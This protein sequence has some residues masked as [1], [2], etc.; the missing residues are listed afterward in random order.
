MGNT[1]TTIDLVDEVKKHAGI[2]SDYAL[3][4][5]LDV[6]PQTISHYRH[7][8]TQMSDEIAVKLS[9]MIGRPPAPILATLAAE[10]SKVPEVARIWQDAAKALI[11]GK[12]GKVA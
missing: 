8:R 4:K 11:R 1:T 6:L 5:R 9:K 7:G 12:G 10:R 3:A 2:K